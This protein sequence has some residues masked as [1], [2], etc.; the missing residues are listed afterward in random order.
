MN[1]RRS[2]RSATASC[3]SRRTGR[4][5]RSRR[6]STRSS[7]RT[8]A[9]ATATTACRRC[10]RPGGAACAHRGRGAAPAQRRLR[11]AR[12]RRAGR[13]AARRRR[14]GRSLA[15]G[16]ACRRR[17]SSP[18]DCCSTSSRRITPSDR[19]ER[20]R[21]WRPG[22]PARLCPNGFRPARPVGGGRSQ[23]RRRGGSSQAK[24]RHADDPQRVPR[25][26]D[27]RAPD[28]FRVGGWV[29]MR[30]YSD[31]EPVDFAIVGTGAGGGTLACRLAELGFS[32]VALRCRP[33]VA[34]ARGFRFG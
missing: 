14:R 12:R 25:G 7:T 28:V 23:A 34:P 30:E 31:D 21:L 19:V 6:W 32:V 9:T 10:A 1:G 3:R 5:C 24:C 13:A 16:A 18:S 2:K 29:P 8:A 33:V 17:S 22:E 4:R 27:G 20:D 11:A 15:T 26:K